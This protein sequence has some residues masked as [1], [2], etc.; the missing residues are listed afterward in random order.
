MSVGLRDAVRVGWWAMQRNWTA[1]HVGCGLRGG[2]NLSGCTVQRGSNAVNVRYST[3][4][5]DAPTKS[6]LAVAV[7]AL[8]GYRTEPQHLWSAAPKSDDSG[9]RLPDLLAAVRAEPALGLSA[10]RLRAPAASAAHFAML[11][12]DALGSGRAA[13]VVV[14]LAAADGPALGA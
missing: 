7:S 1:R 4:A 2:V 8:A 14:N 10:V 9:G 12:Y 6:Q 5:P 3:F 13:L 11:R